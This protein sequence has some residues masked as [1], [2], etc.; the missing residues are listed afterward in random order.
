MKTFFLF[1]FLLF[2]L[3]G[4]AATEVEL[5]LAISENNYHKLIASIVTMKKETA[6]REDYYLEVYRQKKFIMRDLTPSLKVRLMDKGLEL[7]FQMAR[8]IAT[9]NNGNFKITTSESRNRNIE[10]HDLLIGS[11]KRLE[12]EISS[13]KPIAVVTQKEAAK[14]LISLGL[15]SEILTEC[16]ECLETD[17]YVVSHTNIKDRI[18]VKIP[19]KHGQLKLVIGATFNRQQT[20]FEIEAELKNKEDAPLAIQ[21]ISEWLKERNFD[22]NDAPLGKRD[23]ALESLQFLN[24][25]YSPELS[26]R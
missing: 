22:F 26:N 1:F 10:H 9:E 24:R 4:I 2:S 13:L 17:L 8:K 3:D 12:Q 6:I 16:K 19:F 23:P 11:L 18:A 21:A 14:Y 15:I 5:N 7:K 25:L 20:N